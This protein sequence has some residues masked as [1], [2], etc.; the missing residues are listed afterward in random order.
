[1]CSLSKLE[2][3]ENPGED[4]DG[5]TC[6]DLNAGTYEATFTIPGV[7][8]V[9]VPDPDNPD[10]LILQLPNCTS[11]HSNQGTTCNIDTA[12]GFA[13]DTK[14]K[15]VCDD[16]FTV[17]VIVET[18]TLLVTKTATPTSMFEP[19]GEV[20]FTVEVLNQA[21][22]V[23]VTIDSVIDDIYGD[24]A[25]TGN[26]AIISTT[27]DALLDLELGPLASE[28]CSFFA[29]VT[30][31]AGFSQTDNVEVC[32]AQ[33]PD[34]PADICADDDA[35][36]TIDDVSETPAAEKAATLNGCTVEVDY[37]VTVINNSTLDSLTVDSLLDDKFGE[38]QDTGNT[39]IT[40]TT[41]DQLTSV[42]PGG[43][44]ICTFTAAIDDPDCDFSHVDTVSATGADDDSVPFDIDTN[45]VS[46]SVGGVTINPAP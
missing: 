34:D 15:C 5:D 32:A 12:S 20:E 9:G 8:C 6:G 29:N 16:D 26:L 25:D 1:V 45:P 33:D 17:P 43:T 24:V 10:Q 30:G 14:S 41:C 37:T 44:G 39:L 23:S 31:D 40:N 42:A 28:S 13:P 38:L 7:E 22:F 35:T 19:G 11:W 4:L 36:V 21:Q 27:C 2:P 46:V 18:A 3:D